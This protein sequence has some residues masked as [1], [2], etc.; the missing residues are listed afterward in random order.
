ME[1]GKNTHWRYDDDAREMQSQKVSNTNQMHGNVKCTGAPNHNLRSWP[2]KLRIAVPCNAIQQIKCGK[3]FQR[4]KNE[5]ILEQHCHFGER[6]S[7]RERAKKELHSKNKY[8]IIKVHLTI[9]WR[10]FFSCCTWKFYS[11]EQHFRIPASRCTDLVW[12]L[13]TSR[14]TTKKK[15]APF[16]NRS[17][18]K[19]SFR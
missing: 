15:R 11:V 1:R 17:S 10:C 3:A 14:A 13:K 8:E 9:H 2:L 16:Q 12:H 5:L 4:L 6:Y 19:W 18:K 7:A